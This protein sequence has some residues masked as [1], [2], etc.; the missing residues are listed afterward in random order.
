LRTQELRTVSKSP[1]KAKGST[2]AGP[3][4]GVLLADFAGAARFSFWRRGAVILR[5]A[6]AEQKL[7]KPHAHFA[8]QLSFGIGAAVLL[9]LRQQEA[10]RT[11]CGWIIGYNRSHTQISAG[12]TVSVLLDPI[13]SVGRRLTMRLRNA[14]AAPLSADEHEH[15]RQEWE[16]CWTRGWSS[17]AVQETADRVVA[18]LTLP[19]DDF[20]SRVDSRIRSV[21]ADL[22]LNS[23]ENARVEDLAAGVGLSESR[24]A[25]LFRY[26][27]G[28]PI[29]QYR[30]AQR[31]QAALA[32]VAAGRSLTQAAHD[33]GF[34]DSAHFSRIC[35]RMFG[36]APS[37]LPEAQI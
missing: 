36:N 17:A 37:D 25:H 21:L 24:L 22:A 15:A 28:I 14:A 5:S 20:A 18:S 1:S 32:Q 6:D 3:N 33:A 35:K 12:P 7:A 4:T 27:V 13:S 31:T 10:D 26:H 30:L 2:L 34:A 23:D 19:D 8:I 9:Q 16:N 11:A 29:R